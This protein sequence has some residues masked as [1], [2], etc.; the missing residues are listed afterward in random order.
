MSIFILLV[1]KKGSVLIELWAEKSS[2]LPTEAEKP[3]Y[4]L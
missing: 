3:D 4:D 2:S 1:W